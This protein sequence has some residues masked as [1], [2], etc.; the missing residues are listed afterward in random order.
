MKENRHLPVITRCTGHCCRVFTL[1]LSPA[2]LADNAQRAR[3]LLEVPNID[4][5]I[6]RIWRDNAQIAE[7]VVYLGAHRN[8]PGSPDSKPYGEPLHFYTCKNFDSDTGKCR[9]YDT[10]PK[11]CSD[12]PYEEHCRYE[13]CT[14]PTARLRKPKPKPEKL[15]LRIVQSR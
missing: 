3:E 1:P 13:G 2:E 4:D 7:M 9:A 5:D 12:Y 10:R 14:S 6:A 8:Y 15:E 11:M